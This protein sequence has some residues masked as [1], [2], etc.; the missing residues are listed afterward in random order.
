M[1][2][3]SRELSA[4]M[5]DVFRKNVKFMHELRIKGLVGVMADQ[6]EVSWVDLNETFVSVANSVDAGL[7]NARQPWNRGMQSPPQNMVKE[8]QISRPN[9]PRVMRCLLSPSPA[10]QRDPPRFDVP[11]AA[12]R[13]RMRSPGVPCVSGVPNV[14]RIRQTQVKL[15]RLPGIVSAGS[16]AVVGTERQTSAPEDVLPS[17]SKCNG[18]DLSPKKMGKREELKKV[19]GDKDK[20]N[21]NE[22]QKH[23]KERAEKSPVKVKD[24]KSLKRANEEPFEADDESPEK[25]GVNAFFF[26]FKW[27]PIKSTKIFK[28]SGMN[29][30]Q[31]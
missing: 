24:P 28:W 10:Q 15:Q 7:E 17:T 16:A 30:L 25:N 27:L 6:R 29:L 19:N 12:A 14:P 23:S 9:N 18:S 13:L 8:A 2:S 11:Q 21:G 31:L 20:S 26:L 22:N 1:S 4:L 3:N 5:A